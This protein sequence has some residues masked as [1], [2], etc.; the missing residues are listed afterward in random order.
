MTSMSITRKPNTLLYS[1][2]FPEEFIKYLNGFNGFEFS[3]LSSSSTNNNKTVI[4]TSHINKTKNEYNEFKKQYFHGKFRTSHTTTLSIDKKHL[5]TNVF[6]R[7]QICKYTFPI[8]VRQVVPAMNCNGLLHVKPIKLYLKREKQLNINPNISDEHTDIYIGNDIT[9]HAIVNILKT[10]HFTNNLIKA[11]TN[12]ETDINKYFYTNGGG[13]GSMSECNFIEPNEYCDIIYWNLK[14]FTTLST[15]HKFEVSFKNYTAVEKNA[16]INIK[17]IW[18]N[19]NNFYDDVLSDAAT[20]NLNELN[21]ERVFVALKEYYEYILSVTKNLSP[22]AYNINMLDFYKNTKLDQDQIN[23]LK[24][25]SI[26]SEEIPSNKYTLTTYPTGYTENNCN[27]FFHTK[28]IEDYDDS[29]ADDTNK[30]DLFYIKK[31][32]TP[33]MNLNYIFEMQEHLKQ[34]QQ[35]QHNLQYQHNPYTQLQNQQ[36]L[37][38]LLLKETQQQQNMMDLCNFIVDLFKHYTFS[39]IDTLTGICYYIKQKV[40]LIDNHIQECDKCRKGFCVVCFVKNN[41]IA[42]VKCG[43]LIC[44][45]CIKL[46]DKCPICRSTYLYNIDINFNY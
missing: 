37:R 29:N 16:S 38:Q 23:M 45:T 15:Y 30:V 39:H 33:T 20:D 3:L 32:F 41:N 24:T 13:S 1:V 42:L 25:M 14:I 5:D 6:K 18:S 43:H 35:Q 2:S 44:D 22:L 28:N 21:F 8:N 12:F 36:L 31:Y 19:T 9:I 34:Q 10:T 40:I 11:K 17:Y 26:I 27:I 7:Y 46:I 4:S